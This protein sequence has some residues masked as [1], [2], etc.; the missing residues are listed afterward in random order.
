MRHAAIADILQLRQ[1]SPI[2]MTGNDDLKLTKIAKK[3]ASFASAALK[4][5]AIL[6]LYFSNLVRF[7]K[8]P[9]TIISFF[10]FA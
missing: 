7:K 8:Q 3:A 1:V 4:I 6:T 9:V 10:R 2:R 5:Q